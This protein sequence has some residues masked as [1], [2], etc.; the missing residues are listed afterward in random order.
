MHGL[1]SAFGSIS[2]NNKSC[3]SKN[4]FI[5]DCHQ[6]WNF[7]SSISTGLRI[8]TCTSV[9]KEHLKSDAPPGEFHWGIKQGTSHLKD[10]YPTNCTMTTPLTKK[11]EIIRVVLT[12]QRRGQLLEI[13]SHYSLPFPA[14]FL[15]NESKGC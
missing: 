11:F 9:A 4:L 3:N 12:Y 1:V 8:C 15:N 14:F 6:I 7:V 5:P 2:I 10:P 13:P